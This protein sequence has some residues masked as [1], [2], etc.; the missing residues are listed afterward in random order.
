[1]VIN[2]NS[3]E[4]G[5][6]ATAVTTA[7]SGG[8]SGTAFA[9]ATAGLNFSNTRAHGGTLSAAFTTP[10][11]STY[12]AWYPGAAANMQ[13]RGYFWLDQANAGGEFHLIGIYEANGNS[14]M[15][16]RLTA[17]NVLR[18]Y[19]NIAPTSNTW[20]PTTTM[21]ISQW[22]RA[23]LLMEQGTDTTNGRAR[24]A[25]FANNSTTPLAESGW[26]T[27]L[28]LG[29]G[30]NTPAHVRFG[31][32]FAGSNATGVY[33]DDLEIRTG[34]DYTGTWIGPTVL[35]VV[36]T[37]YR[38]NT[39]TSAYVPLESYRWDSGT[40]TYVALDRATP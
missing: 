34:A 39:G 35:P 5:T 18:L 24:V 7:N 38:W 26:V 16:F 9:A 30:T 10:A 4:G 19:K 32:M 33:M 31:K 14:V 25:I 17:A 29:A 13:A 27:G 23:E 40:S 3:F 6:N 37:A 20:A 28:N 21:P 2:T 12:T 22:V 8:A 1:M 36:S 15:I 11:A